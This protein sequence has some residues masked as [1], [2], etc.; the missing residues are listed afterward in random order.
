VPLYIENYNAAPS[1]K[2]TWPGYHAYSQWGAWET[3]IKPQ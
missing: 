2:F 1:S 3:N